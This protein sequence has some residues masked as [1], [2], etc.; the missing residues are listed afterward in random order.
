MTK[1]TLTFN[2]T[3]YKP[4]GQKEYMPQNIDVEC[5]VGSLEAII[6]THEGNLRKNF[7]NAQGIARVCIRCIANTPYYAK[8]D[9]SEGLDMAD[10]S[11]LEREP[12]SVALPN[13]SSALV[14][15]VERAFRAIGHPF[16][17]VAWKIR[18]LGLLE[19][20]MEHE[21]EV[22]A[23]ESLLC[24][25]GFQMK[26]RDNMADNLVLA[27]TVVK[28][29]CN[30]IGL[31]EAGSILLRMEQEMKPAELERAKKLYEDYAT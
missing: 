4:T 13:V 28:V 19:G 9:A 20:Y 22:R 25:R 30:E 12:T 2:V 14:R 1:Q 11:V 27:W 23:L 3:L 29:C 7:A 8:G 17:F 26:E 15:R 16:L 6:A 24:H 21:G 18:W 31:R 5:S 10:L